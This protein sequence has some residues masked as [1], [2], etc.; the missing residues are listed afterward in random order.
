MPESFRPGTVARQR[1]SGT[2]CP[3]TANAAAMTTKAAVIH[4]HGQFKPLRTP[5]AM[6]VNE[7]ADVRGDHD[8][9]GWRQVRRSLGPRI[10]YAMTLCAGS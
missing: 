5:Y 4:R 8:A 1:N 9:S 7:T 10:L 2:V 3:S 6:G